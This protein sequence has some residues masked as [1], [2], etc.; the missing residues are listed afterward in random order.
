MEQI[1]KNVK[2]FHYKKKHRDRWFH[3][4]L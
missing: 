2:E 4:E 3:G 1:E